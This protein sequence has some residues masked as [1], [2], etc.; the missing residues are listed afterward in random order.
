MSGKR[1]ATVSLEQLSAGF[2]DDELTTCLKVRP[3]DNELGL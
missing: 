1:K 3:T 2:T